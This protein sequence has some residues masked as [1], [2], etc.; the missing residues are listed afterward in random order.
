MNKQQQI[1]NSF[2][3]YHSENPKVWELFERFTMELVYAGMKHYSSRAIFDRIRWHV[4]VETKSGQ[5]KIRN[6]FSPYYSRLFHAAYP[7]L[8]GFFKNREL[9]TQ[10]KAAT[11]AE[12]QAV[13]IMPP[14][15][16]GDLM[17]ELTELAAKGANNG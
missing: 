17:A 1:F 11:S 3:E 9:T 7:H 5:F 6:D 4:E 8:D 12:G 15:G 13:I 14:Q 16:E 10:G 2:K